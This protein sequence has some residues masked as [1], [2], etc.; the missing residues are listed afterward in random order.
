MNVTVDR[1]RKEEGYMTM[2]FGKAVKGILLALCLLMVAVIAPAGAAD[3]VLTSGNST[4]A[5]NDSAPDGFS[6]GVYR[7]VANNAEWI[8][9]QAFYYRIGT[10]S[11]EFK[12][13]SD[14]LDTAALFT[15]AA[16]N[17]TASS[18][19]LTF[20]EKAGRF[21]MAVT[22]DLI[23]GANGTN[24]A[25]LKKNVV[26]T[27]LT[28][29]PLDFHLFSLSDYD[30]KTGN[31]LYENA[32]IVGGKAY[33]SNFANTTD[34]IGSG[35]TLVES[36]TV[37][38]NLAGIDN[39]L[40]VDLANGTTPYNIENN[41]G[42]F[43]TNGD[44]QFAFQWDL[45][46]APATPT[47]FTITDEIYPTKALYLAK[48]TPGT[49]VNY[50]QTFTNTYTFDNTRNTS[51]P[52]SNVLLSEKLASDVA[53]SSATN[54]GAYDAATGTVKWNIPQLAAGVTTQTALGTFMV[55]SL[56]DFTMTTQLS[57]N[58]AFP[59]S[60][61]TKSKLCNY[62][63][64]ITSFPVKNGTEG[65]PYS[66]Q[67]NVV[68][69]VTGATLTYSLD[70]A[71]AGMKI[72]LNGLITWTPT[73]TQTGNNAVTVKVSDGTF[74][75]TQTYILFIAYVNVAPVI[76]SSPVT[77]AF[78]GVSYPYTVVAT[79]ANISQG[80]KIT[81]GLPTAPAGMVINST[82]GVITWTPTAAQ[83]GPQNVVVHVSDTQG[84]FV[85]QSFT[86]NV[87]LS[88]KQT[89]VLTWATPAA[90]TYG[91][92]LSATQL[93][94]TVSGGIPGTFT[95][96]PAVGT[97]LNAGTQTL[98]VTFTPSDSATYTSATAS[99]QITVTKAALTVTA[100]A[101]SKV[102]GSANPAFTASYSGFV[103]GDTSAV[104]TGSPS[105]TTTATTA[106][107]AGS[108]P[109]TAAAGTLSASNYSFSYV[110]GALSVTK[111]TLTV[112]ADNKSKT[113]GAVNPALTV[114][115]SGFVNGDS[116]TS[117]TTQPTASTTATTTSPA[118]TYPITASGGVSA[119]YN[120]SYVA[121][122]LTVSTKQTPVLT[123]AT[124]A[125]I[126]YGTALS[127]TQLN[128]TVSGGI[129]GTF[130]Y[131]PAVGTVLN[132]GT[133]TLSVTFT[134][135]DSAT[136]TSATASVQITVNPTLDQP[137]TMNVIPNA[138]LI[139][140]AA[141]SYQVVA[142][143]PENQAMNYSL[144]GNPAGMTISSTGLI[145][146]SAT[147]AGTYTITVKA[148]DPGSLS[149][150][151]SFTLTVNGGSVNQAPVIASSPV[152]TGYE[153]GYYYYAVS[154]TDPNG[155]VL[156][157]ALT[158]KP[159]GM[160][161][162]TK[163]GL[164]Y[165]HPNDK[166]SYSVIVKVSDA[167]GLSATQSF[168]VTVVNKPD[169]NDPKITSTAI[170]T[171]SVGV[172][173]AY[174]VNATDSNG[175][176]LYYRLKSAPSGMVI[177]VVSG[178]ISWTPAATQTGSQSVSVEVVDIK[179]GQTSQ[180]FTIKVSTSAT[181]S[182]PTF[183]STPVTSA[184]RYQTYQYAVKATD[185]NGDSITYSLS[186]RPSGMSIDSSTGVIT[187]K[188]YSTGSYSVSVKATDSKGG[189]SYQNFY[190]RVYSSLTAV[191]LSVDDSV[192]VSADTVKCDI[193]ADGAVTSDDL[194]LILA[195][196]GTVDPKLDVDGN[197]FVEVTDARY[198]VQ[199][200]R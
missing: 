58:E 168:K 32:A 16:S 199:F 134:P 85:T 108:Y 88:T 43:L 49:C 153:D 8:S 183:T 101:K 20:T 31:F 50:G 106:S 161:I 70:A 178:L 146:W 116:A 166:G 99:V 66:Y 45:T 127:A 82:T 182:P 114:S 111:A 143:D 77:S 137:P 175:D 97:V 53:F 54:G 100:D 92:A 107:A 135:S 169:N 124:P 55:N 112:T 187:W 9:Q 42:P 96:T 84:L 73:S 1:K 7:W 24:R 148:T 86:I 115:Y 27:N 26:I 34:T 91:T 176:T 160:T 125:A 130:T 61:S 78:V 103:N 144:T 159:S 14:E 133:Q 76:T 47:S 102:Y 2:S 142:T 29:S 132:A 90:I 81:Y 131:T 48:S 198:C 62:P 33:Q 195:G 177:D 36:A 122:T 165:W 89:P 197:G 188:P 162:N 118:G 190:V 11:P 150:S 193:N 6:P 95:Y 93:N 52:V 151:Q 19:T 157:Y 104:L 17:Q 21:S 172:P 192:A 79:D 4:V 63:P 174:D 123:W 120:F 184:V 68:G 74:T 40:F 22:Y 186:S 128:A 196:R 117:L 23:G 113:E 37:P 158:T 59:T 25:T 138:T 12:V 152:T 65:Q 109:I 18:V 185:P 164:I 46:L 147:V 145:S 179:G 39:G 105:L 56:G 35:V 200:M 80:D 69:G 98:S 10:T 44:T 191:P 136:Y 155:D 38:P 72:S 87:S 5:I 194:L 149:A 181:N 64:S 156:S 171:A 57:S 30:I 173:Y 83:V 167:A 141:F 41:A 51:T 94:A 139:A 189:S 15:V 67:V 154:A 60:L 140:P 119:N 110:N 180:S 3:Y 163:T 28:G 75:V 121:G 170:T 71:P 126:T 129:P 13:S